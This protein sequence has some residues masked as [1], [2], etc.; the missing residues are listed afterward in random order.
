MMSHDVSSS[1]GKRRLI[2]SF[3]QAY[4]VW[5]AFYFVGYFVGGQD[6]FLVRTVDHVDSV[7]LKL[8]FLNIPLQLAILF[9]ATI[10]LSEKAS[11]AT[12]NIS[13]GAAIAN[14]LL[15]AV[16]TALSFFAV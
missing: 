8:A 9:I 15:I 16:H 5:L 6:G 3:I 10:G 2:R 14:M 11:S 4:V 13:L 7:V 1:A 12:V